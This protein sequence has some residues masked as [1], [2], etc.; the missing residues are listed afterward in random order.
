MTEIFELDLTLS[1]DTHKL[2]MLSKNHLLLSKNALYPWFILVPPTEEIEFYN[3]GEDLQHIL[4]EQI[5]WVSKFIKQNF[6]S[7]KLNVATIGNVVSQLHV[8]IIGRNPQDASWPGVVWGNES[9]SQYKTGQVQVIQQK[10]VTFPGQTLQIIG[11]GSN[12]T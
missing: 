2:G 9:F 8:H 3:L 11:D 4:L 1:K 5:N 10:L 7:A 6:N 12:K